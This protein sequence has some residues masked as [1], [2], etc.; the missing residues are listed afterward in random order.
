MYLSNKVRIFQKF[1]FVN[2]NKFFIQAISLDFTRAPSS[3]HSVLPS[4]LKFEDNLC[5]FT[6]IHG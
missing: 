3:N 6:N 4:P 1:I 2:P 5:N